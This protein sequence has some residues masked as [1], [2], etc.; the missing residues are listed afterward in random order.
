MQSDDYT[1]NF[2]R[3]VFVLTILAVCSILFAI[4]NKAM[5]TVSLSVSGKITITND[6]GTVASKDNTQKSRFFLRP[7][8][9]KVEVR[10]KDGGKS[11]SIV[12]LHALQSKKL[13][14]VTHPSLLSYRIVNK[15]LSNVHKITES[16]YIGIDADENI[17]KTFDNT[18]THN[19]IYPASDYPPTNFNSLQSLQGEYMLAV[20][21][22]RAPMIINTRTATG[23]VVTPS[24]LKDGDTIATSR[25]AD[26]KDFWVVANE[27]AY[28]YTYPYQKP[29]RTVSVK[30]DITYP[31][32]V[33]TNNKILFFFSAEAV[34]DNPEKQTKPLLPYILD[35]SSGSKTDL[36]YTITEASWS[37]DGTL[38]G[39]IGSES[40]YLSLY[41]VKKNKVIENVD[42]P[43]SPNI[44]WKDE[45]E[46]FYVTEN[47]LWK[48]MTNEHTS[49]LVA[50]VSGTATS[51]TFDKDTVFISTYPD[52]N[53]ATIW[54][55]SL[56]NNANKTL[57][58][59]NQVLPYLTTEYNIDYSFIGQ[60]Q[61]QVTLTAPNN[62][63]TPGRVALYQL[64]LEEAKQEAL[65][66]INELGLSDIPVVF[67]AQ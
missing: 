17:V 31:D 63:T 25:T 29:S 33:S 38:I 50:E 19:L 65:Q 58:R 26:G 52:S 30:N 15:P 62:G 8:T 35:T 43:D 37:P 18:Q 24:G 41:D 67:T 34:S 46:L 40:K 64:R 11:V 10:G 6:S 53:E 60:P 28:L 14:I 61:L 2:K 27:K 57:T 47:N 66:K 59:L 7:G 39:L 1:K 22:Q 44:Y 49:S 55:V 23:I 12:K 56:E 51:L 45:D 36:P 13:N 32:I 48:Y 4:F 16:L 42:Q 20:G 54:I 3:I 21:S 5:L 9:Y